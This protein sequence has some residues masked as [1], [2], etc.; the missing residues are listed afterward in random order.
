MKTGHIFLL[1]FLLS[2]I[3]ACL[4]KE[5]PTVEKPIP[6]VK[7]VEEPIPVQ[8]NIIDLSGKLKPSKVNTHKLYIVTL[9]NKVISIHTQITDAQIHRQRLINS[10]KNA[11]I[12][13]IDGKLSDLK[14]R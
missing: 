10:G 12:Y 9:S 2:L 6:P 1:I 7:V 5:T 14:I 13:K 3:S 11:I 4:Q 8:E